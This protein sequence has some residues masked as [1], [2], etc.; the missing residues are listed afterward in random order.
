[1]NGEIDVEGVRAAVAT[2]DRFMKEF[3]KRTLTSG[4]RNAMKPFTQAVA[5]VGTNRSYFKRM[6]R[7]KVV[8]KGR[9]D[10]LIMAGV[11]SNRKVIHRQPRDRHSDA[12]GGY[13]SA[14]MVFYWLNYGTLSRRNAGYAFRN[15]R[16]FKSSWWKGGIRSQ[17]T[18]EKA[19]A[20]SGN[21]AIGKIPEEVTKATEKYLKRLK[22]ND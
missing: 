3:P 19:W 12:S 17:M 11:F 21:Q 16:R 20:I 8:Q 9:R 5:T 2:V 14:Y 10:P 15:A 1:M 13:M 18:V 4:I 6:A 22:I 7:A